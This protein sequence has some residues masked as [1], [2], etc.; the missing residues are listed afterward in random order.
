[1][2]KRVAVA[3]RAA[4]LLAAIVG[5]IEPAGAQPKA[6]APEN[7]IQQH[8]IAGDLASAASMAERLLHEREKRYG[9]EDTETGFA[10]NALGVVRL[11]QGRYREAE[12]LLSKALA[13]R[14]KASDEDDAELARLLGNL[15]RAKQELSRFDAAEELFK[16]ALSIYANA[17]VQP[18]DVGHGFTNL[19]GLYLRQS[20]YAEAEEAYLTAL[21]AYKNA[22][23]SAARGSRLPWVAKSLNNLANVYIDLAKYDEAE[24]L[25][26]QAVEMLE[27]DFGANYPLL[28]RSLGALGALYG[29][30]GRYGDAEA[31]LARA[32]QLAEQSGS[33]FLI[34]T[35]LNNLATHYHVEGRHVEAES[36]FQR[37]LMVLEKVLDGADHPTL[38]NVL[39]NFT[40]LLQNQGRYK[41]AML[42]HRRILRIMESTVGI[43]HLYYANALNSFGQLALT[44]RVHAGAEE[45]FRQALKITKKVLGSQNPKIAG[46]MHNLALSLREQRRY[47]EADPLYRQAIEI[48]QKAHGPNYIMVA[49]GESELASLLVAQGHYSKAKPL[50]DDALRIRETALG[51]DHP[52][53]GDSLYLLGDWYF[54][55][56]RWEEA[57][58]SLRRATNVIA[59]NEARG[60][61]S[62]RSSDLTQR[63]QQF[64]AFLRAA[65][66]LPSGSKGRDQLAGEMFERAQWV[67]ASKAAKALA[68]M[69][70]RGAAGKPMLSALM[71]ERQGLVGEWEQ[72][73]AS[74]IA[75]F[76]QDVSKRNSKVEAANL[77]RLTK[78]DARMAEIDARLATDFPAYATLARAVPLSVGEVQTYLGVDEALLQFIDTS[79]EIFVWAVT[80]SAVRWIRLDLDSAT[81]KREVTALRCGLDAALWDAE[82]SNA[83]CRKLTQQLPTSDKYRNVFYETLPFDTER[84]YALYKTLFGQIEDLIAGKHL[85]VA[86]SG[87]LTQVPLHVLVSEKPASKDF[88]SAR[89]LVQSHPITVLPAVSSLKALRLVANP[90]SATQRMVGFGNPLL[91]GDPKNPL[92]VKWAAQAREAQACKG[93]PTMPIA[94]AYPKRR[95]IRSM[96]LRAGFASLDDLKSQV[97]LPDTAEELCKVATALNLVQDDIF[98]G[99]RATEATVKRLSAEGRLAN[100]RV[101]HFA[102]HGAMA[103]QLTG[104]TEPGLI[105]TPPNKQTELDDGYLSA[106]EISAL[107]LDADWI[108]LSACNTAAAEDDASEA[109]SGLARA[110]FFAG[111]RAL[112]VSH[113]AVA[114][115][116]TV[117]LVTSTLANLV[118]DPKAGRAEVLRRAMLRMID[119]GEP[120]EAH[121][122]FWAPFVVVG[123]G[124]VGR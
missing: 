30:Q 78:I 10:L 24:S 21:A 29:E 107:K 86:L 94:S 43:D 8:L 114:S 18:A 108:V 4:I 93:L 48:W 28:T 37:A 70:V 22:E 36:L 42:F 33:G 82:A 101:V 68:Q 31:Q 72:R 112:L 32:V 87:S 95:S 123:E 102:T 16:R 90:S 14:T 119:K 110:F 118:D 83:L 100:Y 71:R 34:A 63:S 46:Y 53:V 9:P 121:P 2:S 104:A 91:Q 52:D 54:K 49:T 55:Q 23:R 65:D 27:R 103:G 73:N 20:R 113:W 19:G 3:L 109:L 116:T 75:A 7:A 57:V 35:A 69:A 85:L 79:E 51:H 44:A 41:E 105:L 106:S 89:W 25:L 111:A 26:K 97:P 84:A 124:G 96:P 15:G 99:P 17:L 64:I 59:R 38:G 5:G 61:E 40:R 11:E 117:K 76:S 120:R 74:R 45:Q 60:A 66:R 115:P 1:M 92:E 62:E 6:E 67:E 56:G 98:L 80:K 13:I 77:A 122:A 12:P 81:L 47:A 39:S 58:G 50:Y 88:R